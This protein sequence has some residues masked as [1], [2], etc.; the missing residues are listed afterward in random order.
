M[1][2]SS[3]TIVSSHLHTYTSEIAEQIRRELAGQE[4]HHS[5]LEDPVED[6]E[7][8]NRKDSY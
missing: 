8:T 5:P 1:T 6:E 2:H 3:G 4:P 7:E